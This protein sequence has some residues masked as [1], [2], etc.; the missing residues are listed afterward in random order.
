MTMT[1]NQEQLLNVIANLQGDLKASE[2][3]NHE[4]RTQ[5]VRLLAGKENISLEI[6][7]INEPTIGEDSGIFTVEEDSLIEDSGNAEIFNI[8]E[9]GLIEEN[10]YSWENF[11]KLKEKDNLSAKTFQSY[12]GTLR[13]TH[14]QCKLQCI[15]EYGFADDLR[16]IC[17]DP[18]MIR[19][20]ICK[21]NKIGTQRSQLSVFKSVC[22]TFGWE[23]VS[24]VYDT[25][26]NVLREVI[27]ADDKA[28]PQKMTEKQEKLFIEWEDF[29][30]VVKKAKEEADA[31]S[32]PRM[33]DLDENV[34]KKAKIEYYNAKQAAFVLQFQHE[35]ILRCDIAET[36]LWK[37]K[38]DDGNF[39]RGL[40]NEENDD[41]KFETKVGGLI[42]GGYYRLVFHLNKYKTSK[43]Y[44]EKEII[45]KADL[46]R[47]VSF[48]MCC[49]SNDSKGEIINQNYRVG[50]II[51]FQKQTIIEGNQLHKNFMPKPKSKFHWA[52]EDN[53]DKFYL[54]RTPSGKPLTNNTFS[55]YF[56]DLM[57]KYTGK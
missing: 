25:M 27:D 29:T 34:Y 26:I 9:D 39:I 5:F 11:K 54:L 35:T 38:N 36:L 21:C 24:N 48:A 7:E 32:F 30:E 44:G 28:N 31:L 14:R 49:Y 19:I 46:F 56:K 2:E 33:D 45:L 15:G 52:F 40:K 50:Q 1:N 3:R 43:H 47:F 12:F 13:K 51:N 20:D 16:W 55:K 8:E 53:S 37:N 42:G 4:L 17:D 57:E 6:T 18:E 10:I 41:G 23:E 22:D